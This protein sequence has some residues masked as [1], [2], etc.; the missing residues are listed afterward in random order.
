MSWD[1]I[2]TAGAIIGFVAFYVL[3]FVVVMFIITSLNGCTVLTGTALERA[4]HAIQVRH[5]NCYTKTM[6][7]AAVRADYGH[8]TG[9]VIAWGSRC[10]FQANGKV[11]STYAWHAFWRDENGSLRDVTTEGTV[12]ATPMFEFDYVKGMQTITQGDRWL[13]VLNQK[14][15]IAFR[16][17][18]DGRF[19]I[20]L[21]NE[22]V[23]ILKGE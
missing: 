18:D 19:E 12:L 17:F 9:I 11:Q 14:S 7:I 5:G 22:H 6:E 4:V 3:I 21:G 13:V 20:L 1:K 15:Y 8:S 23:R 16:L 2:K 10:I